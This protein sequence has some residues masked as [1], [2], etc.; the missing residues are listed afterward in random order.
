[1]GSGF[2]ADPHSQD[3]F[4]CP[5]NA[6]S[7]TN[8]EI[9]QRIEAPLAAKRGGELEDL[10]ITGNFDSAH[11]RSI[12]HHLFQDVFPWAGDFR[13]VN[14]SKGNSM[15]GPAL[16]IASALTDALAKLKAEYLLINLTPSAFATRSAFY[17]GE[18]NAIH[19]FREGN[20]RAQRE[21]I[22]QLALHAG[23]SLSWAGFTQTEMVDASILSHTVGDNSKLAAI[24]ERALISTRKNT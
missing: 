4:A 22:R 14:I 11:L 15:F 12:H 24:I 20:G 21:L 17:L 6:F 10:G 13:V 8:Y 23:H 16:H 1:V 3:G 2:D 7:I 19:P 18:L 5:R 9:L